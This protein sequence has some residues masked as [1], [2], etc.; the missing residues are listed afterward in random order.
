MSF[1]IEYNVLTR[2][3]EKLVETIKRY[4]TDQFH[5]LIELNRL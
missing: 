1:K 3:H 5:D 4:T 2:S